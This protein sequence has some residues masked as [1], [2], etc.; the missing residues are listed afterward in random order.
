MLRTARLIAAKDMRLI[1]A[2]GSGLSQALL[3][4]LLLIFVF[5]LS[6]DIGQVMTPQAAA[7]TF[8]MASAFCQVLIF[9]MLYNIEEVN[10]ARLGL[11]LL[12][13]GIEAV[14]LGKALAGLFL[15]LCAQLFFLPA[16]IIFL[17]Q[18][19]SSFWSEALL[20]LFLVDIGIACLGSLLGALSQGQAVRES[21]FSI[22]IFP[23]LVPV[24]LAGIRAGAAAFNT[25]PTGVDVQ[26]L[27]TWISITGSFDAI[28]M[29]AGLLLFRFIYS[30][31]D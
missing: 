14:W 8:W 18:D 25:L 13:V 22:I 29:G 10:S 12:P 7:A 31:E 15:L 20:I 23:L 4:G 5:S 6:M 11:L 17:G 21:L 24:L 27:R 30:G 3:L 2:R 28:F 16:T 1:L 9:G 19:I 26:E